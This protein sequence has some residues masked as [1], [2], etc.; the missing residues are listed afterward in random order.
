MPSLIAR[1]LET[2]YDVGVFAYS[3]LAIANYDFFETGKLYADPRL[4]LGP[5][6][7][8]V[9]SLFDGLLIGGGG[10][11]AW[12]HLPI[13]DPNWAYLVSCPF[14]IF[15]CG[16][17]DPLPNEIR[18]LVRLA[19]VVSGRD[20][21]SVNALTSVNPNAMLCPDP[22]LV[23]AQAPKIVREGQGRAFILRGPPREVHHLIRT[24]LMPE[25]VVISTAI[26]VDYPLFDLFP[27]MRFVARLED[28]FALLVDKELVVSERFHGAICALHA[29]KK[30]FGLTRDDHN[31]AKIQ[32][33]L[34]SFGAED[35]CS[36]TF[37]V[38]ERAFPHQAAAD[39]I[40]AAR[41]SY[42]TATDIILGELFQERIKQP[43]RPKTDRPRKRGARG[44]H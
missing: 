25:D 6:N 1:D 29:G 41:T 24:T 35:F 40:A 26:D 19:R 13:W 38:P 10:L 14:S 16:S 20:A 21:Y 44:P 31:A 5:L 3:Q 4:P 37:A 36:D 39:A 28:L 27:E 18:N 22:I 9:L 12:P 17:V 33:L 34:K 42:R 8:V 15:A 32:E 23:L 30:T 7:R 43:R 11:L 2:R